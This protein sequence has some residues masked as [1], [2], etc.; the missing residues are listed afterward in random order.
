MAMKIV[1][2]SFRLLL[3]C[4]PFF[5]DAVS[6]ITRFSDVMLTDS[7]KLVVDGLRS[8]WLCEEY[9]FFCATIDNVEMSE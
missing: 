9:L 4:T 6:S 2:S 1:I 5:L 8:T 7:P 3:K